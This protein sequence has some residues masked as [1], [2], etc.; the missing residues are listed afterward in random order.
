MTRWPARS[1]GVL[2]NDAQG[3]TQVD[4][5]GP[6][7][8]ECVNGGPT[9][10]SAPDDQREVFTPD[11]MTRPLLPARMKEGD[12]APRLTVAGGGSVSFVTVTAAGEGE[13]LHGGGT[14][15]AVRNDVVCLKGLCREGGGAAAVFTSPLG[16]L[17]DLETQSAGRP[18]RRHPA[19]PRSRVRA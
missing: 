8:T 16:A 17:C 10:G 11:K 7:Q 5:L 2:T 14:T 6:V 9:G 18:S 1:R 13:I 12:E 4:Q 3:T 15:S 19:L